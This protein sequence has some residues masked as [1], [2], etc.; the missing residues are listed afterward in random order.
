MVK[1]NTP[2]SR[3]AV[4]GETLKMLFFSCSTKNKEHRRSATGRQL[5]FEME[6]GSDKCLPREGEERKKKTW[7]IWYS[8]DDAVIFMHRFIFITFI[9]TDSVNVATFKCLPRLAHHYT[10]G[11]FVT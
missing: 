4:Q 8:F 1:A 11:R 3:L 9:V 5:A 10:A 7:N 6:S 2:S